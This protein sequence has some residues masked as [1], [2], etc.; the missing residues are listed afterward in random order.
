MR[1]WAATERGSRSDLIAM[2]KLRVLLAEDQTILRQSLRSLIEHQPDLEVV[3]EAGDGEE[4][5]KQARFLQP[6]IVVM[7]VSMPRM[8]GVQ[9]TL[10]VKRACPNVKV[11]ALTVHDTKSQI[12]R[13][14]QA[15]ASGYVVKRSAAEELIHALH[16][17]AAQ[18]VYLDPIVAAKLAGGAKQPAV[19]ESNREEVLS[20]REAEVLR[21]IALGYANKEIAAQL[22]LS[23]KT[24]ETFKTRSMEKLGLNSRVDIVRYAIDR[25]WLKA[26]SGGK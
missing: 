5:V 21:L 22:N 20:D 6:D 23:V 1:S 17:V 16:A 3:G 18:G 11:L 12:R 9:A 15:G 7:D 19:A 10:A 26:A 24:V 8:D 25:G 14:L 4:A 13:V 2:K